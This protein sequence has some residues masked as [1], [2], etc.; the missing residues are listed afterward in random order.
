MPVLYIL[1]NLFYM[2]SQTQNDDEAIIDYNSKDMMDELLEKNI[3]E[4]LLLAWGNIDDAMSSDVQIATEKNGNLKT[5]TKK[6]IK[7]KFS[8]YQ[9]I[10]VMNL[11]LL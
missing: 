2:I 5:S 6:A 9:S 11:I 1:N 7:K 3:Q 4:Y 8:V 10:L